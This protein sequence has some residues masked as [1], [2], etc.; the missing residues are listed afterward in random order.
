[1]TS[2]KRKSEYED[3]NWIHMNQDMEQWLAVVNT[4]IKLHIP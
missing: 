3:V 1:M 4:E 2:L